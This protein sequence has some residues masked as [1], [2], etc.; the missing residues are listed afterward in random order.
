MMLK[1]KLVRSLIGRKPK[2]VKTAKALG[3][4]K[5]NSEVIVP[6]NPQTVGMV[7]TIIHLVTVEEMEGEK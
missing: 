4:K 1:V 7:N 5:L 2:Q 3:L 6:K